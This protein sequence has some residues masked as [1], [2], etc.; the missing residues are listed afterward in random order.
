MLPAIAIVGRPNVGKS[1]LFNC[2]TRSRDALVVD[3]PGITRDRLYGMWRSS[4]QTQACIVVD[5]G[6]LADDTDHIT[7]R[8]SEQAQIAI[9]ESDLVMFVVDARDGPTAADHDI[10]NRLRATGKPLM[11]VANKVD[12]LDHDNVTNEFFVLGLGEAQPIAASHRSGIDELMTR[13]QSELPPGTDYAPEERAGDSIDVCVLGRP[14]VGKSTLVNQLLGEERVLAHDLPGTTRD[15]VQVSFERHG[16]AFTLIDTAGIRRRSRVD[17]TIEKLSVIKALQALSM[18]N[19]AILMID[20][21]DTVT[22]QDARLL[23]SVLESGRALVI[24]VNKWDSLRDTERSAV[25][26][27]LDRKLSF[28]E[29]APVHYISALR[30]TGV[31]KMLRAV[32]RAHVAAFRRAPTPLLTSILTAAVTRTP[33]PLVRGRR[34][35]LRYAHQGGVNPPRIVVHGNQTNAVPEHYKRYLTRTFRRALELEGTP[36]ALTFKTGANPFEGRKNKLTPR[37][38]KRRRRVIERNKR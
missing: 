6:G 35:K 27:T 23:G 29:F 30:G 1:T 2:L 14:N 28:A 13:A 8:I 33:P 32:E 21:R 25:R 7:R 9:E 26:D 15:S 37:Q 3:Q 5:T 12:G 38:L 19:V 16:K 22:D 20:A 24:A 34:I 17:E 4:D 31:G 36:V 11:L 18:A 10:V